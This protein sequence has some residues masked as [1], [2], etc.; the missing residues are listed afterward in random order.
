M[1]KNSLLFW[2]PKV[3]D[4]GIRTP[5]TDFVNLSKKELKEYYSGKGDTCSLGRLGTEVAQLIKDKFDLP[6]FV[7]TD[8]ISNKHFWDKACYV[9]NLETLRSHL[10]EIICCSMMADFL[11]ALPIEAIVVR[12]YIPM[13]TRFRAFAGNMPVN[14]ERRY[15]IRDGTVLCHHSYWIEGAIQEPLHNKLPENWKELLREANMETDPEWQLLHNYARKIAKAIEG[16]WS[17][18]FCLSKNKEWVLIDMAEGQKSWHPE[19]CL[20]AKEL[21]KAEKKKWKPHY[22]T[23][24][25]KE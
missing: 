23:L 10:F 17:V 8:Q 20:I 22:L 21:S 2:Y 5:F 18:D 9:D 25:Q 14:P 1:D 4:L 24:P 6:V 12:E 3:K 11:G 15:F 7:R 16:F 19:D 13:D